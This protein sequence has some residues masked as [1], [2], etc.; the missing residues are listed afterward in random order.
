MGL[1][2]IL[3]VAT[4]FVLFVVYVALFYFFYTV[5]I[6]IVKPYLPDGNIF[7]ATLSWFGVVDAIMLFINIRLFI[8]IGQKSISYWNL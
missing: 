7:Y 1:D 6:S 8:Y 4:K 2:F 5:I 3:R